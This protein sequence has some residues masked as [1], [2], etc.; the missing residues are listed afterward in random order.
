MVF[1]DTVQNQDGASTESFLDDL[2]STT[3]LDTVIAICCLQWHNIRSSQSKVMRLIDHA[4]HIVDI[5][6]PRNDQTSD[7]VWSLMVGSCKP[8]V[9]LAQEHS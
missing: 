6:L 4:R 2:F 9:R 1:P 5:H 3:D 7:I 8:L